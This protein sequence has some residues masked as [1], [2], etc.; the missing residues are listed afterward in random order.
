[1]VLQLCP[2]EYIEDTTAILGD[3]LPHDDSVNDR[4]YGSKLCTSEDLTKRLW[5]GNVDEIKLYVDILH[6]I[7]CIPCM[8]RIF[9]IVFP[10]F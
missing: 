10:T 1:M 6:F 9:N 2:Q 7:S 4:T 5:K 3:I 8:N